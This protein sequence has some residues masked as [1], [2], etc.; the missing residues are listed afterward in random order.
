MLHQRARR[1]LNAAGD[2]TGPNRA[3]RRGAKAAETRAGPVSAKCW[4]NTMFDTDMQTRC[5]M[6]CLQWFGCR[7][8]RWH[9]NDEDDLHAGVTAKEQGGNGPGSGV[10]VKAKGTAETSQKQL[11]ETA[12]AVKNLNTTAVHKLIE[13]LE[14]LQREDG[15]G[16]RNKAT[17]TKP[18]RA[19]I[20][21]EY[22]GSTPSSAHA[23]SAN[24]SSSRLEM[25]SAHVRQSIAIMSCAAHLTYEQ[26]RIEGILRG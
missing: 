14:V 19:E 16:M 22:G 5:P 9:F 25:I 1:H 2:P 3:F 20:K 15:G 17:A 7:S 21:E 23:G 18:N 12:H 4:L 13:V 26:S 24:T 6:R 11:E 8:W 10:Q